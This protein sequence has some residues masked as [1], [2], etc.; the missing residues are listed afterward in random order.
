L[1]SGIINN[2]GVIVKLLIA[3]DGSQSADRAIE[4]LSRAGVP[5]HAQA[6][7]LSVAEAD[8]LPEQAAVEPKKDS[9]CS[10]IS[11][12]DCDEALK[13][14]HSAV[15]RLASTFPSW[16]IDSEVSA[17]EVRQIILQKIQSWQPDLVVLGS[18][19]RTGFK[20]LVL[21]SVS[22]YI[23]T[24]S[25][26]SVRIGRGQVR[27]HAPRLLIGVDGSGHA[28][29][30]VQTVG[31]RHWPA[32]TQVR[33][34]SVVDSR[35]WLMASGA[36]V[37]GTTYS[38]L[39]EEQ[40]RA[41][42]SLANDEAKNLLAATGLAVATEIGYGMPGDVLIGEAEKWD[43][44]AVFVGAKGLNLVGR[45]LLGSVSTALAVRAPCSVEVVR[46]TT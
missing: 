10:A 31:A 3:Y 35:A 40:L 7:V 20:R 25:S 22:H 41:Q 4:D 14:A 24:R 29:K 44:D 34:V 46:V 15:Q 43:A 5:D 39:I 17:G 12:A 1:A 2:L 33:L 30:A 8:K 42:A 18:H 28:K 26:C 27:R 36:D 38:P 16:T 6:V 23:L 11:S 9:S 13:V 19:G 45:I 21:G 32:G 37:P